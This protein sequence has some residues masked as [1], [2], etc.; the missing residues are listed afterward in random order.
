MGN[1][2]Y[3]NLNFCPFV[4][5]EA[6]F[7]REMCMS[8]LCSAGARGSLRLLHKRLWAQGMEGQRERT[9]RASGIET[10]SE[11]KDKAPTLFVK[12]KKGQLGWVYLGEWAVGK[13]EQVEKLKYQVLTQPTT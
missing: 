4:T 8:R 7:L 2:N 6:G 3:I 13:E 10:P 9:G 11:Q 12:K 1:I 5:N